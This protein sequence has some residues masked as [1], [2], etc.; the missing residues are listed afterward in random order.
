MCPYVVEL[1]A[2][3]PECHLAPRSPFFNQLLL[4]FATVLFCM[5]AI[6]RSA[7]PSAQPGTATIA[8]FRIDPGGGPL[9]VPVTVGD[10]PC[11][12]LLDTGSLACALD[13][14]FRD[15]VELEPNPNIPDAAPPP[16]RL[17]RPASMRLGSIDLGRPECA[18]C[19]AFHDT[20]KINGIDIHGI[21]GMNA[22]RHHVIQ[23]DFDGGLLRFI[24][25]V[26]RG[27]GTAVPLQWKRGACHVAAKLAGE[28]MS[29][30]IGTGNLSF[31][32]G[33]LE[34]PLFDRLVSRGELD[35]FQGRRDNSGTS[36]GIVPI[37]VGECRGFSIGPFER[38]RLIF[39]DTMTDSKLG[40]GFLSRFCVTFDFPR[41]VMY[42]RP[43]RGF[44][45]RDACWL[46]GFG[47]AHINGKILAVEIEPMG[48]AAVAGLEQWDELKT[49]DGAP[50]ENMAFSELYHLLSAP[51]RL[52]LQFR[53]GSE[54]R[55]TVMLL[56]DPR[57][58]QGRQGVGARRDKQ[59]PE[60]GLGE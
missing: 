16:P 3:Y 5:P 55:Q 40:I 44:D 15:R 25:A 43:G 34:K 10:T 39:S 57:E 22:L 58:T 23:V 8:E 17:Y 50:I 27:A 49:I 42:L 13:E 36:A 35:L 33:S 18:L 56:H 46:G 1:P 12:F 4:A 41:S 28:N 31:Y 29:F 11:R 38:D 14:T 6:A 47:L 32:A 24:R 19:P 21:I 26:D 30:L 60:K 59:G 45:R 9:V 20:F 52:K 7:E 53:R 54:D 37:R 51:G 48:A 2:V